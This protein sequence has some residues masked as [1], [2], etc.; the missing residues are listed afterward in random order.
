MTTLYLPYPPPLSACYTNAS[1]RGRVKTRRYRAWA[2]H[3]AYTAGFAR[4][5][6]GACAVVIT[7]V[8]PDNRTRD[9]DNL[10]KP[11]L[12]FAVDKGAIE[13]DSKIVDLR[14]RWAE[15]AD[16]WPKMD[17]RPVR[18]EITARSRQARPVG[19]GRAA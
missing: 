15:E 4:K 7:I 16:S 9:L 12:D 18:I 19:E 2:Q 14:I 1:G 5:I 13:D 17:E 11:L 8:R 3:A 6:R 10:H